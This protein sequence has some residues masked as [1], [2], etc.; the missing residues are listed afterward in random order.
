MF[1]SAAPT[2][3]P[4]KPIYKST[5]QAQTLTVCL[6]Y[7]ENTYFINFKNSK[8]TSECLLLCLF[9]FHT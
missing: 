7:I 1:T 6:S 2:A 4:A 9:T 5:K 3:Q 8:F